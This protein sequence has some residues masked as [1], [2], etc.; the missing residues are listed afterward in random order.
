MHKVSK[1]PKYLTK[2]IRDLP[3]A[4]SVP[5]LLTLLNKMATG[6]YRVLGPSKAPATYRVWE[7]KYMQILHYHGFDKCLDHCARSPGEDK[8]RVEPSI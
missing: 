3:F 5:C 6:T 1:P 7:K 4:P 8:T 2:A